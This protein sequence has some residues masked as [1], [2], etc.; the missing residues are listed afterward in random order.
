MK[1]MVFLLL[2]IVLLLACSALAET[3]VLPDGTYSAVFKT[4]SGMF[5]VSEALGNRGILTVKDG[6]MMI[7]VSL[8]SKKILNL[9]PGTA[10]EAKKEGAAL[11]MPTED[12]VTYEDGYT[13]TVYGFDVP[14]PFLDREFDLA[15]IGT[16]G[17]WY[18]HKV[19]VSEP[20]PLD[21][22]K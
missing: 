16:K 8:N 9:F 7:H 13:E 15:L 5:R 17:K 22:S 3:N 12:E 20:L 11:L 6:Q 4:D 18:D 2:A 21:E 19:S 1:R 14:V 10:E